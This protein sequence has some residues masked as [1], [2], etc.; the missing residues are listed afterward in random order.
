MLGFILGLAAGYLLSG[1][2]V[3]E[4]TS[5]RLYEHE[6][7]KTLIDIVK[8]SEEIEKKDSSPETRRIRLETLKMMFDRIDVSGIRSSEGRELYQKM[9]RFFAE[10]NIR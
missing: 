10:R 9:S 6:Q 2:V 4:I 7:A 5:E 8:T 3:P 1:R